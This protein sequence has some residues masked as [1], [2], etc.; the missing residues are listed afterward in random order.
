MKTTKLRNIERDIVAEKAKQNANLRFSSQVPYS[1]VEVGWD[2]DQERFYYRAKV[3]GIFGD[4]F[5]TASEEHRINRDIKAH[6]E[7]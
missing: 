4:Y 6:Y 3:D 5:F 2:F 7:V 1:I